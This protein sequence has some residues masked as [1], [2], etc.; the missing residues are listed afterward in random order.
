MGKK[1]KNIQKRGCEG[2][3]QY[4]LLQLTLKEADPFGYHQS[5]AAEGTVN[6]EEHKSDTNSS[7][8]AGSSG[9]ICPCILASSILTVRYMLDTFRQDSHLEF[10]ALGRGDIRRQTK[11]SYRQ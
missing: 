3:Y 7:F 4:R 6:V 5:A 11:L 10:F 2:Q 8:F 1:L 9:T